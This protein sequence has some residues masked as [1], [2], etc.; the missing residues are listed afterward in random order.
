LDC[1]EGSLAT[2]DDV[3]VETGSEEQ[4]S[5]AGVDIGEPSATETSHRSAGEV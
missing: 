2:L 3:G 1:L 5:R 4:S